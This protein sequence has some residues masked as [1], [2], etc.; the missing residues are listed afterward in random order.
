MAQDAI[1]RKASL[2][3]V[4]GPNPH[5]HVVLN[6]P[7]YYP[8]KEGESV[9][10][11]CFCSYTSK[12]QDATCLIEVGDHDFIKWQTYV[13]Y[14]RAEVKLSMP[15]ELHVAS[16]IHELGVEVSEDLY[17]RIRQ[18]FRQSRRTPRKILNFMDFAGI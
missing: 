17:E 15:L 2:F 4:T 14:G 12:L 16:G 6:D 5:L 8:P 13:D 3:I 7:I 10:I 11:V 18:G 9:L 1:F